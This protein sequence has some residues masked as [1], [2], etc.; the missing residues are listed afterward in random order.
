MR[1]PRFSRLREKTAPS[2]GWGQVAQTSLRL[3][4]KRVERPSRPDLPVSLDRAAALRLFPVSRETSDRLDIYIAL[5][6]KWRKTIN[7]V[8]D[9]TFSAVWTRHVADSA[10]LRDLAPQA[11]TWIDMGSGAGFPGLVIAIQLAEQ[12]GAAVH[13]VESDQR[14]SAFLREVAQATGA[15]AYIHNLRIEQAGGEIAG[16]VD[17]VTARALAPLPRLIA[18]ARMWLAQGAVGIFPRGQSGETEVGQF[19]D[20]QN[21]D[22]DFSR[23]RIDP[24]SKIAVVRIKK[25]DR[26]HVMERPA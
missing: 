16:P 26:T 8:S 11:R 4:A 24:L 25:E 3:S 5:L 14:K 12:R 19:S 20:F 15:P 17:A 7:L 23:S 2:V 22:L 21:F 1:Q 10:Q 9:A 13:L 18:F 6:A